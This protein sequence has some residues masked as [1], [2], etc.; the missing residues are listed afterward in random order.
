MKITIDPFDT[1]NIDQAIKYIELYKTK[2]KRAEER[3][4]KRLESYGA[5]KA[6]IYFNSAIT[7]Y[8][9]E[10]PQITSTINGNTLTISAS[11]YEVCF[12]EFGAGVRYGYG[13]RGERPPGIVGIG[14][15]GLGGGKNPRGW[16]FSKDGQSHHTFGNPPAEAMYKTVQDLAE[17]I[18]DVVREEF[19]K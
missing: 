10:R 4:L 2:V 18:I 8:T 1:K 7:H 5:T 14:E 13:Y 17:N 12:I 19:N 15:Y 11:G 6:S 9:Q 16:W 3:I